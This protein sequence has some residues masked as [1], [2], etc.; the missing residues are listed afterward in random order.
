MIKKK[1]KVNFELKLLNRM[2][3]YLVFHVSLLKSADPRIS[4]FIE[5]LPKFIQNNKY[6]V[7]EIIGYNSKT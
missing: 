5:I 1:N 4:V 7:K 3:I 6:K 2:R